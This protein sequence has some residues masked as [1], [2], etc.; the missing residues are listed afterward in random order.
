MNQYSE[1][2]ELE[3]VLATQDLLSFEGLAVC[4][5]LKDGGECTIPEACHS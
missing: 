1:L 5:Y 4:D 2:E 3:A